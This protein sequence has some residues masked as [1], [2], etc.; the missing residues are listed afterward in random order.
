MWN[1]YVSS[2]LCIFDESRIRGFDE[3]LNIVFLTDLT[4][5]LYNTNITLLHEYIF[6]FPYN[7]KIYSRVRLADA[8]RLYKGLH[9]VW[10]CVRL[11]TVS[12]RKLGSQISEKGKH[13]NK[14]SAARRN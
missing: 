4:S 5:H 7:N 1:F 9:D 8:A 14:S 10:S 2:D 13:I 6:T 12:D 3:W 11:D